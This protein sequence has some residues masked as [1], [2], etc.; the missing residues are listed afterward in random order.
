[1]DRYDQVATRISAPQLSRESHLVELTDTSGENMGTAS[2]D[3]AHSVP[4]LHRAFSAFLLDPQGRVLLQRRATRKM[5]FPGM[6]ANSCCGHPS[7]GQDIHQAVAR[8]VYEEL[9]ATVTDLKPAG[10]F[11]YRAT[12]EG[13]G[14]TEFEYDHVLIGMVST[15][16]LTPDPDEVSSFLWL[17]LPAV[18]R[19]ATENSHELTPWFAAAW[20]LAN[21]ALVQN[22]QPFI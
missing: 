16:V 22:H 12:D 15:T 14:Y 6:W 7:P 3:V 2:V 13:S 1:M 19:F 18:N 9:G 20:R 11:I 21:Q 17:A 5:R 4:L 8:R 10:T